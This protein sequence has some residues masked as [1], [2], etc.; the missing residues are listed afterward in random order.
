MP[1]LRKPTPA[2][3]AERPPVARVCLSV[4]EAA[5]ST[6]LSK[7]TL[8]NCMKAG[9]LKFAKAGSRRLIAV[10]ELEAFLARLAG[11]TEAQEV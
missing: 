5:E 4:P 8:Y 10:S 3:P 11:T 2:A 1:K 6:G 7:S 9:T